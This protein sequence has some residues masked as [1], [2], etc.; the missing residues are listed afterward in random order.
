MI[1]LYCRSN[2][3]FSDLFSQGLM[4]EPHFY[5]LIKGGYV[6]SMYIGVDLEVFYAR[7]P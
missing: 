5:W 7:Y 6:V 1:S 2:I 4:Y 3:A